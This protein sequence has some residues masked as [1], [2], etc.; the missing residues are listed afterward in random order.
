MKRDLTLLIPLVLLFS[1]RGEESVQPSADDRNMVTVSV[2]RSSGWAEGERISVN[3]NIS[4]PLPEAIEEA[5]TAFSVPATVAPYHIASPYNAVFAYSDGSAHVDLPE[6]RFPSGSD[7]QLWLGRGDGVCALSPVLSTLTLMGGLEKYRRIKLTALGGKMIAGAFITDYQT[8]SPAPSGASDY[9]EIRPSGDEGITLPLSVSLPPGNYSA[10]GFRLVVTEAG[11]ETR[12]AMLTPPQAYQAG[13]AY[14]ID[15]AGSM[16]GPVSGKISVSRP[17][18]AWEAGETVNVNGVRSTALAAADAGSR[19]ASFEIDGVEAPYCVISPAEALGSFN[20]ERGTLTIPSAQTVGESGSVFIGR[21]DDAIVALSEATCTVDIVSETLTGDI[22]SISIVSQGAAMPAGEFQTN[23]WSISGG[24]SSAIELGGG[25]A[26]KFNLPASIVMAPGDYRDAGFVVTVSMSG[27]GETSVEI[28]P[29][30]VYVAGETY[31]LSLEGAAGEPDIDLSLKASTS[32]T[33]TLGWSL[34]GTASEDIAQ[35]Y[36]LSLYNDKAGTELFREYSFPAGAACWGGKTPRFTVPVSTPGKTLFAQ[37]NSADHF[38]AM[39]E[40]TTDDFDIVRMPPSISAP[41]MVLAEDFGELSWDFDA[42]SS[43]AGVSAPSS[44]SSY[45]TPG[46]GYVPFA[47][48]VGNCSLFSYGTALQAS[49]LGKWARDVGTDSR[50]RLHPGYVTLGSIGVDRAWILTPPFPVV[51]GKKATVTV[52][53]TVSR[54]FS[55]AHT[56]YAIG[57]LDNSSHSGAEGG[58]ANMKDANTSDFSWPNERPASIYRRF[59]V[60]ETSSW[61]TL[62][63]EGLV[64][65]RD[66]RIIIGAAPSYSDGATYKNA[67]GF[68]PG[69]NLSD[70]IVEVTNVE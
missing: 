13:A 12:E 62:V 9:I 11:G 17:D 49:R 21:A 61:T 53:I 1:C 20:N 67:D 51:S 18:R 36:I 6:H 44:P 52:T 27:G 35:A 2:S 14:S 3:G 50:V 22:S 59:S 64:L 23:F 60:Q 68:R 32:S 48:S 40:V 38:S 63:F 41:G 66:D 47:E 46:T 10:D 15:I 58:G 33:L 39:L 30:K 25:P 16:P 56:D 54:A 34:G 4:D 70:I 8:L 37:V 29:T 57:V 7:R 42:V 26:G 69:L 24:T 31:T 19:T 55:S 65:S 45:G 43:A 28:L 5:E